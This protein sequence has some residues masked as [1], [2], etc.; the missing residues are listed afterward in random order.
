MRGTRHIPRFTPHTMATLLAL[1]VAGAGTARAQEFGQN[2]VQYRTFDW[3][4]IQTEHFDVYF[5][6]V[7]REAALDAA[8]LAERSYARLSRILHHQFQERKP[9]IV[10]AAHSEFQETNALGG[11]GPEE[12]TEGVTEFYK[13][14]M[15]LPFLGSYEALEHVI[16]HEMVHQFQY[17]VYSRGHP[18]GGV[19]TLIAVNPPGWFMEGMAEYLSIGPVDPQTTMW[20]RD[21]SLEGHLPTIEQMTYDPNVFPY[22]FGHA[23]WAYIGE[24]WGDEVVGEILQASAAVGIEG[25]FKR[26]L[27]ISLDELSKDWRDAVQTTFLPQIGD[28]YRARRIAQPLLTRKRSDGT[29]HLAPALSPDG[30]LI[31]YFGEGNDFFIDLYLADAETGKNIR[32]LVRSATSS[33]YES[34]RFI[35]SSGAFSP[36]GRLFAIAVKHKDKDD[37]VLFDIQ[38]NR[39]AARLSVPVNGI[40]NPSFSPDGK[41]IVFTGQVG[42]LSDLFIINT[43]GSD[44]RRLT[45]DKYAELLPVWSPDGKTIAFVTDRGPDTDFDL[46]KFGNLRIA[47]YHLDNGQ[48]ETL[49]HMDYGKNVNPVWSPDG[50]SLAFISDRTGIANI[51]LYD[52]A[53]K[54]IYQ[55]TDVYTGVAGITP[56]SPALSWARGSDRLAF[57]YYENGSYDVYAIDNPRSLRGQGYQDHAVA[58]VMFTAVRPRWEGEKPDSL[59]VARDT[60]AISSASATPSTTDQ[61]STSVYRSANGLRASSAPA[62]A[63]TTHVAAPLSV[64]A[65]LDSTALA[66]PDTSEFTIKPYK[67][68]FTPDYVARPTIGYERDNFGRGFFGGTAVSLSDMLGDRT[69]VFSGAIN[70]RI[71]EAQVLAAYINQTHRI[72]WAVGFTQDPY[73]FYAPSS[74]TVTPTSGTGDSVIDLFTN[75]ERFVIRDGFVQ[76]FYP[77]NTFDRFELGVHAV[78]ISQATLQ[79][80]DQY[81][82]F[83][84]FQNEFV[85][86]IGGLTTGYVQPTAALTHDNTLF[87][88]VG[89]FSGSRW[90]LEV[91]PAFGNWK[92]VSGLA[93]YRKYIFLR[94]FTIAVRGLYFGRLGRDGSR[95]PQFL[96]STELIRGYTAGSFQSNEC[97]AATTVTSQT[98]CAE[99]DQLIGSNIGVANIEL[100]FPLTR[101]LVLGLLPVGLPPI[102]GAFFY[103]AGV[104]FDNIQQLH[105][106]R[107][108]GESP[109]NVRIPLRSYGFGIRANVFGFVILR[110]DYTKPLDRPNNPHAYWTLSLGPTF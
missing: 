104:A 8:R 93:D 68:R 43:D 12:G 4:I 1:A 14:R 97:I 54:Q 76:A 103:D 65:L 96:G 40:T 25:A 98:G 35:Y 47:L 58:P 13:H 3:Q 91:S 85:N 94:P 56:L 100:R 88:Y 27:G 51:F 49:D 36:D 21:A 61:P 64:K 62:A 20:L 60:S 70:G 28:H 46:L 10:Y 11:E 6:P 24:R 63:E 87:G 31:A 29:L 75:I 42:G 33:N 37:L 109:D 30:R 26:A 22:R 44:L 69:M 102:E 32:R 107:A 38:K 86:T 71:S 84:G 55:L 2:K 78:A 19:Q 106:S 101:A 39:E 66:L 77:F 83:G 59:H 73:Y 89:P 79:I 16:Q 23:L 81:D 82:Q 17:D 110:L 72:N 45:N 18:G 53:A 52:L 67:V 34:L 7:E 99:L 57:A 48:I 15:V 9:I 92:F 95:F 105:W 41:Q 108:A 74:V 50:G 80:D 90:R 5:Y